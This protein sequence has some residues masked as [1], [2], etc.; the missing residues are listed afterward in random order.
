MVLFNVSQNSQEKSFFFISGDFFKKWLQH[1]YFLGVFFRFLKDTYL[2]EHLRTVTSDRG[3][4]SWSALKFQKI[5]KS[6]NEQRLVICIAHTAI[7][8]G[9]WRKFNQKTY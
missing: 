7:R 6:T 9:S 2:V 4:F 3:S 5:F 8:K 1:C